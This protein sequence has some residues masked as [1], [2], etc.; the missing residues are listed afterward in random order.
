M[1]RFCR[2]WLFGHHHRPAIFPQRRCQCRIAQDLCRVCRGL[3]LSALGRG[4]LRHAGGP[5]RAQAHPGDDDPADGRGDNIDWY[6][7]HLCRHRRNGTAAADPD[8]LRPGIFSRRRIRRRLRLPDGACAQRQKGLVWQLCAGIDIYRF[9]RRRRGGLRPRGVVNGRGHGQLGLAPAV[10][11]C[12]AAGAGGALSALAAGRNPGIP[13]GE[14]GACRGP[15]TAQ[16]NLAP[17][18][19]GHL[20]SGGLCVAHGAVVLYVHDLLCDL[21]ASRGRVESRQCLAGV[22]DRPA[23]RGGTVP[24][25]RAVL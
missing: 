13:G 23:L 3:C 25:R 2:I 12:R 9:C 11:D 15:L 4:V 14:A 17:S 24:F 21:P 18:W 10:S 22:I 20:L 19:C 5:Y 7:A 1:V 6:S 16:G 8:P